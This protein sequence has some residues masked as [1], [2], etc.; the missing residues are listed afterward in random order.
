MLTSIND[1]GD[2]WLVPLGSPY[3][4]LAQKENR[5]RAN[6]LK[7]GFEFVVACLFFFKLPVRRRLLILECQVSSMI[8]QKT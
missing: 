1:V 6:I 5:L 3:Q 4:P 8:C 2:I 7:F